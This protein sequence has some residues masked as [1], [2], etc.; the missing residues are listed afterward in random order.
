[1]STQDKIQQLM[2]DRGW[3]YEEDEPALKFASNGAEIA[4]EGDLEWERDLQIVRSIL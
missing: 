3:V 2:E 4:R 1:M